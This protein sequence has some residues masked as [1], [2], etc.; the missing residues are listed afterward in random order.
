M[1]LY[2]GRY[3]I[4]LRNFI[5][6]KF[7]VFILFLEIVVKVVEFKSFFFV[8]IIYI[9]LIN[10]K[11]LLNVSEMWGWIYLNIFFILV[12]LILME[13]KIRSNEILVW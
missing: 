7:K 8:L 11:M 12:L 6:G 2:L 13:G 4:W 3:I 10:C 9:L 1:L 5:V